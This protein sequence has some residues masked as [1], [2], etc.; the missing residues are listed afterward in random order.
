MEMK[1]IH[2]HAIQISHMATAL[3]LSEGSVIR[4]VEY[5]THEKGIFLWIEVP[6]RVTQNKQIRKFKIFST[7]DGIPNTHHYVGTAVDTLTPEAY[8]VYEVL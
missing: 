1:T 8:H 2:K 5:V 3:E 4:R 6:I 7:G